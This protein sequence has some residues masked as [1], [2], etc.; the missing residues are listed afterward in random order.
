MPLRS[1]LLNP[2]P[3]A[4]P[5][6]ENL[7]WAPVYDDIREARREEEDVGPKDRKDIW[8]R[9]LKKADWPKTVKLCGEVLAT[10][11]K[12]MQVAAWLTEASLRLEGYPGLQ[13]G[14]E[15]L[16]GLLERF[17]DTLYPEIEDGD[18]ELR[19]TPL[20]WVG[21]RL[22]EALRRV[23]LTSSGLDWFAY[24]KSRDIGYEEEAAANEAKRQNREEAIQ[25]KIPTAED[26]DAA[27]LATP[28]QFFKDRTA[29]LDGCLGALKALDELCEQKF[30]DVAPSLSAMRKTLEDVKQTV[31][32]LAAKKGAPAAAAVVEEAEAGGLEVVGEEGAPA[33]QEAYAPARPA[34]RKALTPEPADSDDAV[35]RILVAARFL[36][37]Q[38]AYSPV[39]YLL[40]RGLRWGELRAGGAEPDP[41]LLAPPPTEVRQQMKSL[42]RD[43]YW[44]EVLETAETAMSEPCGRAWLDLQRYVVRA[45]EELG[46]YYDLVAA[47]VRSGVK[48]LL[49][50]YPKLPEWTFSDDTPV[51][52]PETLAWLKD[53]A[54]PSETEEML[55]PAIEVQEREVVAEDGS[56]VRDAYDVALE[57]A[58]S[59]HPAEAV[60]ILAREAAQERSGRARFQRKV[61]LAQVCLGAGLETVAYPVLEELAAEVERRRLEEWETQETIAHAL[62]L[63]Y[64]AMGKLGASP[65]EKQ[66]VYARICRLDP[67]QA[68]A[69]V[70]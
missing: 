30:G 33:V 59:G 18:L 61:Q 26:F 35:A 4:N 16:R 42:A 13:G 48:G 44:Q 53:L 6:G 28:D 20:E 65:E 1:D 69:C 2:I 29:Q 46:S 52:N 57:A 34:R 43:G 55:R 41:N 64:R 8:A 56:L 24:R 10:Q 47:A 62:T 7:R 27:V 45:C 23:T 36:R 19:A 49:A 66:K 15:L 51:A 31:H 39:P 17:W 12:D 25:A 68:L 58:R 21:T 14:L 70:R 5:S 60:E 9:E 11:S 37:Q 63:L 32:M 67:V 3:G 40:L 50:D 22:E 38:D 54:R